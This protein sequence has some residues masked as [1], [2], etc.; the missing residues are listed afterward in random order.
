M[1]GIVSISEALIAASKNGL[2]LV[3]ISPNVDPP[4]CKILDF[5]KFKYETKKKLQGGKKKQKTISLK[6]MK[7]RPNIG[8]GDLDIK[9]RN[10]IKFL[11]DGDKVKVSMMFRGREI[12]HNQLGH[13]VFRKIIDTAGE[14]A[15]IE[16]EPKLEGK[17]M[18][19]IMVP[20]KIV[21]IKT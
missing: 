21:A 7:F 11:D 6:E 13:A 12:V 5:G 16:Y 4:V 15:K 2:D 10:I 17:Q 3:E 9:I 14:K 20:N 1:V 18:I 8:S 19:M